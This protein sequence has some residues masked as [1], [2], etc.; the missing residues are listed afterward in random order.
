MSAPERNEPHFNCAITSASLSFIFGFLDKLALT[1]SVDHTLVHE[2]QRNRLLIKLTENAHDV[3]TAFLSKRV[4]LCLS[5]HNSLGDAVCNRCVFT[6]S[7]QLFR[8][9]QLNSRHHPQRQ[10]A[11]QSFKS[12]NSVGTLEEC[13]GTGVQV[14]SD[15]IDATVGEI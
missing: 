15:A 1:R 3:F 10:I 2:T 9:E 13:V 4:W 5:V 11:P 8:R 7:L 14:N 12:D 6:D